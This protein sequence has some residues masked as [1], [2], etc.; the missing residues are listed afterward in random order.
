MPTKKPTT[1]RASTPKKAAKPA[2]S[3]KAKPAAPAARSEKVAAVDLAAVLSSAPYPSD[4]AGLH[5]AKGL[6]VS[7]GVE[8]WLG[9]GF[10]YVIVPT[11]QDAPHLDTVGAFDK[12]HPRDANVM[13]R[14]AVAQQLAISTHWPPLA[15]TAPL[16]KVAKLSLGGAV[17]KMLESHNGRVTQQLEVLFGTLP[18]AEEIVRQIV[19]AAAKGKVAKFEARGPATLGAG[20]PW[21]LWR[22]PRGDRDRLRASLHEVS[23]RKTGRTGRFDRALD[24]ILHGRAGV[25]RSGSNFNGKLHLGDLKHADDDPEWARDTALKIL[26][27]LRPADREWFDAQLVVLCGPRLLT[28]FRASVEKFQV[29]FRPAMIARLALFR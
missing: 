7:P 12:R 13:P 29:A 15:A 16:P 26:E 9:L 1:K 22:I 25:E 8:A 4:A 11:D 20:L 5:R 6:G 3:A 18:V 17:K 27:N 21:L 10:P 28:A 14:A 2:R 19:E 23:E 24:V